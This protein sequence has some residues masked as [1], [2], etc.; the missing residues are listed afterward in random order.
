[1]ADVENHKNSEQ[2]SEKRENT[3]AQKKRCRRPKNRWMQ[4]LVCPLIATYFTPH[5]HLPS[6]SHL[7]K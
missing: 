3:A 6:A 1:M 5:P 7:T 2:T 4:I